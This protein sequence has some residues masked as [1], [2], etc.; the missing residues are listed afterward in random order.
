[1]VFYEKWIVFVIVYCLPTYY[2][3][4]IVTPAQNIM[5]EV[6]CQMREERR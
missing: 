5:I 3:C 4:R 6:G 2:L 1:M